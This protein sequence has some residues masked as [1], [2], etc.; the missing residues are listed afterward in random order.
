MAGKNNSP[1]LA[2]TF[3]DI[4]LLPG[5]SDILPKDA[6]L[7]TRLSKRIKLNIP[8]LSAA[9]DTVTES[10]TAIAIA[11]QGGLGVVHRNMGIEE[12]AAEVEKVKRSE[13]L[14][15]KN[16]ICVQPNDSLEKI[17][18][19]VKST[20]VKSFPVTEAG[21]V[22]GIIT[23]R[24]MLF[25]TDLRKKAADI[26]TKNVITIDH[27][28]SVEEAKA[29][30]HKHRVEKLPIVDK[31]KRLV[32]MLTATDIRKQEK[33]PE[34]AKDK[35]GRLMV[36]AA[37]G[38][39]D[40]ERV[41][42]LLA[43]DVD[44]IFIDTAHGH[45]KMVLDA[46]KRFKREFKAEVI[47]GNVATAAAVHDLAAAGADAIKV[48]VGP[49][50]ICTTRIVTGVGVPQF[51]AVMHCAEAAEKY[52]IPIIADG[53]VKYSGDITKAI[54]AGASSVMIGSIF[55]GCDETPGRTIFLNNRK[56]KQYR[57]MGSVAAMQQGSN[58]RYLQGHVDEKS[59]L[60]PEGV[61]G[62][63]PFKG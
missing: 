48:G 29:L 17:M 44:A 32:G 23:S 19:L 16:P 36:A 25:E 52:D 30:L 20:K 10:E 46:V 42:K 27:E 5:S 47:A 54:A 21:K 3:D 39:S 28:P 61:E 15:I 2:L 45:S 38:P 4:L 56:F 7:Q 8:L 51:S 24:D 13:F 37:V 31:E 35:A 50:S 9:M 18:Q 63:V 40:D 22:V 58:E 34:A 1:E 59:K 11:R 6:S 12:Q 55:A 57:G 49:G 60:V 14:I 62:I 41:A 53:G 33:F 26:M 43:V